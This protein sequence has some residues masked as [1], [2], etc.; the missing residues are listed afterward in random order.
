MPQDETQ[1]SPVSETSTPAPAQP[2]AEIQVQAP[3]T[4]TSPAAPTTTT[5]TTTTAQAPTVD[6]DMEWD[7]EDW[8]TLEK[9]F[10]SKPKLL[11]SIKAK[12][13]ALTARANDISNL[14]KLLGAETGDYEK[15][16]A[17][18]QEKVSKYEAENVGLKTTIKDLERWQ[19]EVAVKN[20]ERYLQENA[21]D[22]WEYQDESGNYPAL[23]TLLKGMN[24]KGLSLDEALVLARAK[25]PVKPAP[26]SKPAVPPS[27]ISSKPPTKG[28][29]SASAPETD[30][31]YKVVERASRQAR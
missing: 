5:T 20:F 11:G 18:A 28:H 4:T 31:Y 13:E 7:G 9:T 1:T 19:D 21:A 14:E 2:Q 3:V 25:I 17:E 23:E 6:E 27:V 10:A 16:L 22:V 30:D 24:D 8:S 26:P 15:R 12:V 29:N